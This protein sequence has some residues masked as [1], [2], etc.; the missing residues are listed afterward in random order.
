MFGENL[1][2]V[3]ENVPIF[4]AML[5]F[6]EGL[7]FECIGQSQE[8]QLAF[9]LCIAKGLTGSAFDMY[10]REKTQFQLDQALE[11]YL[12]IYSEESEVPERF[13][14]EL[15]ENLQSTANNTRRY[16]QGVL[17]GHHS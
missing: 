6:T 14:T 16:I 8:T 13:K 17:H 15:D 9:E 2:D 7:P 1:A 11:K 5:G 3:Q 12:T 10:I 4:R